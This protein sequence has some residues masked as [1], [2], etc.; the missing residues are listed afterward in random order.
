MGDIDCRCAVIGA[1][2][3]L[4]PF[5]S[6]HIDAPE[7]V[8]V[9]DVEAF[10]TRTVRDIKRRKIVPKSIQMG[11]LRIVA[12][13]QRRQLAGAAHQMLKLRVLRHIE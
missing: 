3:V 10:K 7:A 1:V 11:K 8:I 2:V 9:P 6:A 13:I 12:E 4:K 5:V